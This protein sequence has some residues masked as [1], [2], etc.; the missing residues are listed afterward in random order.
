MTIYDE[1]KKPIQTY[2]E[3]DSD[4]N[5]CNINIIDST[6]SPTVP[7]NTLALGNI[8]PLYKI[9]SIGSVFEAL[10]NKIDELERRIETLEQV[11]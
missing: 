9:A 10:I 7:T 8:L 4:G 2:L 11:K 1:I 6:Y 3:V 5:V